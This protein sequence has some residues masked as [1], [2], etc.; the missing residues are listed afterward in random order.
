MLI[1]AGAAAVRHEA[2]E[3]VELSLPSFTHLLVRKTFMSAPVVKAR[4]GGGSAVGLMGIGGG[5]HRSSGN[6]GNG[7]RVNGTTPGAGATGLPTTT[8]PNT[9]WPG[10][11]LDWTDGDGRSTASAAKFPP[12]QQP[13]GFVGGTFQPHHQVYNPRRTASSSAVPAEYALSVTV[14]TLSDE[15]KAR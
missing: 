15:M 3:L 1:V 7:F 9:S 11:T 4:T 2:V 14:T 8:I 6:S 5:A 10:V 13:P 12:S